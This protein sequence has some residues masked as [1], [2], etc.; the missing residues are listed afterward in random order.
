MSS[1]KL[2]LIDKSQPRSSIC[3]LRILD[4]SIVFM[5]NLHLVFK[6]LISHILENKKVSFSFSSFDDD[7]DDDSYNDNDNDKRPTLRK[8][9]ITATATDSIVL[10]QSMTKYFIRAFVPLSEYHQE[11]FIRLRANKGTYNSSNE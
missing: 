9:R 6:T 8:T 7:D 1:I 4:L 11:L 2:I 10:N 5:I 3:S